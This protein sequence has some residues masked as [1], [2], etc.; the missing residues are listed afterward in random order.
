MSCLLLAH[1]NALSFFFFYFQLRI[2]LILLCTLAVPILAVLN[3]VER[4]EAPHPHDTYGPPPRE[5]PQLPVPVY[6]APAVN[7]YPPPPPDIPP[8][9]VSQEY[10]VP[11]QYGP[12]KVQVEYGPPPQSHH[13]RSIFFFFF[14][15]WWR[16]FVFSDCRDPKKGQNRHINKYFSSE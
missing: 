5:G 7:R 2:N 9:A 12:P 3:K 16:V 8:P 10:G 11:V 6:G 1:F 14:N 13:V 4:R 15:I